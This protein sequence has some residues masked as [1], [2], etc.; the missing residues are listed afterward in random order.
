MNVNP[1][2]PD[3]HSP[4]EIMS[5]R[6]SRGAQSSWCCYG[7]QGTGNR[8]DITATHCLNFLHRF[9]QIRP[10]FN[11]HIGN[12]VKVIPH[13]IISPCTCKWLETIIIGGD[14]IRAIDAGIIKFRSLSRQR[15]CCCCCYMVTIHGHKSE[16][17]GLLRRAAICHIN[18]MQSTCIRPR[19]K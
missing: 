12:V 7:F 19:F 3:M 11:S 15:C 6:F 1:T 18:V 16:S 4:P 9:T 8:I 14:A 13:S 2:N 17:R 10:F 5:R